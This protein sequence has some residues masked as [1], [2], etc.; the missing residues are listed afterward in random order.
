MKE[1]TSGGTDDDDPPGGRALE[2]LRQFEQERGWA[3]TEVLP[4]DAGAEPEH[5]APPDEGPDDDEE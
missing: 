2:R 3:E 4:E 5:Q 1:P